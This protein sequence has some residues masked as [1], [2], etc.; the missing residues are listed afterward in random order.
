MPIFGHANR[1]RKGLQ[2]QRRRR[3]RNSTEVSAWRCLHRC[4]RTDMY[5]WNCLHG[6]VCTKMSA[7]R[8]L[9]GRAC[10]A[11]RARKDLRGEVCTEA[12]ARRARHAKRRKT[13]PQPQAGNRGSLCF[14]K[15]KRRSPHIAGYLCPKT[16]NR[17]RGKDK[18]LSKFNLVP[19][20]QFPH[21]SRFTI[22]L[23]KQSTKSTQP[24]TATFPTSRSLPPPARKRLATCW[25]WSVLCCRIGWG[26]AEGSTVRQ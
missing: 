2:K 11:V 7:R 21:P 19:Q 15:N 1:S 10:A 5:V 25:S 14:G 12:P 24:R 6:G 26:G 3:P 13:T 22:N 20:Q 17:E 23:R 16:T 18:E 9:H 4:V 8:S